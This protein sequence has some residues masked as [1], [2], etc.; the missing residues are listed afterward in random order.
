MFFVVLC[1]NVINL[2]Y[3]CLV[4]LQN[5]SNFSGKFIYKKKQYHF[6]TTH[7]NV[8]SSRFKVEIRST[9]AATFFLV[10]QSFFFY[11]FMNTTNT[12]NAIFFC[13]IDVDF[14]FCT[15]K[16]IVNVQM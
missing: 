2:I 4:H 9:S 6:T 16:S 12:V 5:G 13:K 14:F 11:Y 15:F 8:Q 7:V 10:S 3:F 1:Y